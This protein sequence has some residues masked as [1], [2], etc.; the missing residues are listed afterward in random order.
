MF[1]TFLFMSCRESRVWGPLFCA[2]QLRLTG[3]LL[4]SCP[5]FPCWDQSSWA[6]GPIIAGALFFFGVVED[7]RPISRV[8]CSLSAVSCVVP[9]QHWSAGRPNIS[10]S[11]L[12]GSPRKPPPSLPPPQSLQTGQL[13]GAAR[14]SQG[15]IHPLWCGGWKQW[16]SLAL[17]CSGK[18]EQKCFQRLKLHATID[19]CF[20][21]ELH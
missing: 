4:A 14:P 18:E 20:A 21:Y 1:K 5:Q 2:W 7:T 11:A 16:T 9:Q 8:C 6:T 17:L 3:R 12:P 10:Q 15:I 19:G 13:T